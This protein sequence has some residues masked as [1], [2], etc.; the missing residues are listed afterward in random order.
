MLEFIT[1]GLQDSRDNW[2]VLDL[3]EDKKPNDFSGEKIM[4][5]NQYRVIVEWIY[6]LE[7]HKEFMSEEDY[8]V[9]EKGDLKV[10]KV[11]FNVHEDIGCRC[12]IC[13]AFFQLD[14]TYDAFASACKRKAKKRAPSAPITD[15][16][17]KRTVQEW[18]VVIQQET[19]KV[20]RDK[21]ALRSNSWKLVSEIKMILSLIHI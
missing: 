13:H 9:D 10:H 12:D 1:V 11:H 7:K 19:Q 8:K 4:R 17:S 2:G 16:K 14:M 20:A 21:D 3:V 18:Q 15:V 6:D 5:K